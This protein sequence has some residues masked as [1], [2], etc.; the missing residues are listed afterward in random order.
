MFKGQPRNERNLYGKF[1]I[2][3]NRFLSEEKQWCQKVPLI[4]HERLKTTKF[5]WTGSR[6]IVLVYCRFWKKSPCAVVIPMTPD[7]VISTLEFT[8]AS[9]PSAR[10]FFLLIH[11]WILKFAHAGEQ[12]GVMNS[13]PLCP[14]FPPPIP[15]T[16]QECKRNNK[17]LWTAR[18]ISLDLQNELRNSK[19]RSE[20]TISREKSFTSRYLK[21]VQIHVCSFLFLLFQKPIP[22][23]AEIISKLSKKIT[24][25]LYID[26]WF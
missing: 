26:S 2:E 11:C 24:K 7:K 14:K 16:R 12:T 25:T 21:T 1:T 18:C 4:K 5:F 23:A 3:T 10:K 9:R 20:V 17:L 8:F 19:S 15:V 22:A 13:K 6:L